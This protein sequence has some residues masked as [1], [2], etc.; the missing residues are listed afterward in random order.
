MNAKGVIAILVVILIAGIGWM[1][2]SKQSVDT[3][4]TNPVGGTQLAQGEAGAVSESP[5]KDPMII[6]TWRSDTDPKF[7][8]EFSADG[9]ATDRYE[10]EASAT[11]TGTASVV[12]ATN[13]QIGTVPVGSL[14]GMTV[15]K[16]RDAADLE[17]YLSVQSVTESKLTTID[18]TG[19]GKVTTWTR[20][21]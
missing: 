6:G 17:I 15:I 13:L 18:L 21:Q 19:T 16:I 20:V 2:W 4:N 3:A 7:T 12:D 5:V 14:A 8:R 9:M 11:W 1:L 10:G